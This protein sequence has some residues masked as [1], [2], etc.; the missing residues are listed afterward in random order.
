MNVR[1]AQLE[2]LDDERVDQLDDGRVCVHRRA[3]VLR[4]AFRNGDFDI[5]FRDVL[6]HLADRIVRRAVVFVQRRVEVLLARDL[7]LDFQIQQMMQ[8]I[9]RVQVGRIGNRDANDVVMAINGDDAITLRDVTRHRGHDVVRQIHVRQR[10]DLGVEISGL[11][12]R[13]GVGRENV[14]GDEQVKD[15]FSAGLGVWTHC[16]HLC[17]GHVAEFNQRIQQVIVF[18]GHV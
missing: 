16:V 1:G 4:A 15:A 5:T 9:N 12:L 3:I 8:R 7:G 6:D 18:G 2:G 14:P 10:D 17:V 13:D 11:G